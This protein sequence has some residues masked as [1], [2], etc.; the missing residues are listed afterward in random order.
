MGRTVVVSNSLPDHECT[1]DTKSS[2]MG[3]QILEFLTYPFLIDKKE[4]FLKVEC[5]L[6]ADLRPIVLLIMIS[7][8]TGNVPKSLSV[9]ILL[10]CMH[11]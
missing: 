7:L 1:Y 4:N 6:G 2:F 11:C 3:I 9:L 8:L 5:L 10:T